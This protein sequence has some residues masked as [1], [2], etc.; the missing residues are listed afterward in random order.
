MI[1]SASTPRQWPLPTTRH[2]AA[3]GRLL[4]Y[5]L[6]TALAAGQHSPAWVA[7]QARRRRAG[8]AGLRPAGIHVRAGS[9]MAGR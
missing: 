5:Y 2:N 4:D 6:N 9:H 8:P 7:A 3:I 1:S